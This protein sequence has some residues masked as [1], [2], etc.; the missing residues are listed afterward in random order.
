MQTPMLAATIK[1]INELVD[2]YPLLASPKLDGIRATVADGILYSRNGK[3]IRNAYVQ[4]ILPLR[5]MNG[6]D[7]ELIV[8]D[9]AAKDAFN[10]T[11]SGVMAIEDEPDFTFWV[12]DY[13]PHG[14]V[15]FAG[16]YA[17]LRENVK[18][19]NH[20]HIQLVPHIKVRDAFS[21]YDYETKMLERGFEGIML[22]DPHGLYKEG[23]STMKEGG[24]MKLKRF[25]DS[26][27]VVLG[28]TEQMENTNEQV[29]DDVGKSR[30]S[31]HKSGK[32]G[33]STLGSL[34]VK[35]VH[36]GIEFD[37]G[38]GLDDALRYKLWNSP[39]DI[40]GKTI[41]YKYQ[42]VG[43]KEKPRFPVYLGVRLD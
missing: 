17:G 41:K 9:P 21:V 35:D 8:G 4:R 18:R 16:R 20:A 1:N 33:K 27:A 13:K 29:R 14:A 3:P 39:G 28:I 43:V 19:L 11:Q 23:R 40:I 25:T 34:Q 32:V 2:K 26:E 15:E 10:I 6:W 38:T 24:L 5:L 12:F 30:R 36:T 22:R 7:G 42:A 31:S 37:I